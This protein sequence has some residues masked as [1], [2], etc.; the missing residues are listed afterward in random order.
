[1]KIKYSKCEFFKSQVHYLGFLVGTQGVQPLPEKVATIEALEPPKDNDALR[2]FWGLV[3]F[4]RKFTPFFVDVMTC[5]NT[6]MRKGAVFK[7][8]EHCGNAF[9]LLKLELVMSRL[10]YPNPNKL[11][12]LFTDASKHSYSGIVHP[13][14]TPH[15]LGVE[16]NLI[17][18]VY[19]SGSFGNSTAVE[20]NPK[21]CYTVYR[22]IQ[23]FDFLISRHK[24][25]T[26]L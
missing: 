18:V 24:I 23:K 6:M 11:F 15:H 3:G 1:M 22:S 9:R 12:M 21:G 10:Q 4:Y 16:V 25:H 2:Q 8:K 5:I 26:V 19:F 7:W 14:E 17:P 13:E 20:H